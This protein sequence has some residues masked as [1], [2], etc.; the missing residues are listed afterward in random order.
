MIV[1]RA[2]EGGLAGGSSAFD[3]GNFEFFKARGFQDVL[4]EGSVVWSFR[5]A[6]LLTGGESL[7]F[8][9]RGAH[10][11]DELCVVQSVE[12][13]VVLNDQEFAASFPCRG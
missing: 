8:V 6:F 2:F 9:K 11:V 4:S 1:E 7:I 13:E 5:Q 10:V 3:R 12:R